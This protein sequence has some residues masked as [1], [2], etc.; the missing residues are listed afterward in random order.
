MMDEREQIEEE[1]MG[2]PDEVEVVDRNLE[3]A[4]SGMPPHEYQSNNI[5]MRKDTSM[6]NV[7]NRYIGYSRRK[8]KKLNL[9]DQEINNL[10]S[11]ST[12]DF[13]KEEAEKLEEKLKNLK[14]RRN[15]TITLAKYSYT[16][17]RLMSSRPIKI[18]NFVFGKIKKFG[19]FIYNK[20]RNHNKEKNENSIDVN[21]IKPSDVSKMVNERLNNIEP[22]KEV[23]SMDENK[24]SNVDTSIYR[25]KKDDIIQ[26]DLSI[27]ESKD[28]FQYPS[29]PSDLIALNV[30]QNQD[31]NPNQIIDNI[32]SPRL[33]EEGKD[34]IGDENLNN[35]NKINTSVDI[36][37]EKKAEKNNSDEEYVPVVV[38]PQN[39]EERYTLET[40]E[41][42]KLANQAIENTQNTETLDQIKNA[43]LDAYQRNQELKESKERAMANVNAAQQEA[44]SVRNILQQK[45]ADMKHNLSE[46]LEENASI[47]SNI[48]QLESETAMYTGQKEVDEMELQQLK[49]LNLM[50]FGTADNQNSFSNHMENIQKDSTSELRHMNE[51]ISKNGSSINEG[52]REST[53]GG[54]RKG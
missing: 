20:I 39:D 37:E 24:D 42:V 14:T 53:I 2:I 28:E 50:V 12:I 36:E 5:K 6:P 16:R 13:T 30:Y 44:N 25:M 8:R 33:N 7:E 48:Q 26:D 15:I 46:M 27:P 32:V 3:N 17:A 40:S 51:N 21:N 1:N 35:Q 29:I 22:E 52:T 4:A 19:S 31:K 47:E 43:L 38:E 49:E 11:V 41:M 54:A 18:A 9:L 34:S 45:K 10:E 23:M